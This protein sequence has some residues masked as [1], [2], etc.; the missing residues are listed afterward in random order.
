M[1]WST[2][3]PGTIQH[4]TMLYYK[5]LIEMRRGLDIFTKADVSIAPQS[6]ANRAVILTFT[7][8]NGGKAKVIINPRM[9]DFHISLGEEWSL[10]ADENLAGGSV[11][12]RESSAIVRAVSM[13]VYINDVLLEK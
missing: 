7:D 10:V 2:L 12:R 8:K 6:L 9:K 4:D 13:R 3:A 1:D 5:G 11:I